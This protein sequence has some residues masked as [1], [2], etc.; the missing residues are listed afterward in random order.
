MGLYADPSVY[1]ILSTPGT[2]G[3]VDDFE[4]VAAALGVRGTRWYEPACGTGRYLRVLRGRGYRAGGYDRD[5]GMVAYAAR[6]LGRSVRAG[7]MTDAAAPGVR[8]GSVDVAFNP[9][10]TIRHL[11]S[12]ADMRAHFAQVARLL[13]PGGIYIVGI[14]LDDPDAR[15]DEDLWQA[16]RGRCR[17]SQLV[18]YLPPEPG[19]RREAVISHL[20][21][22]RPRGV[23][24]FDDRYDLR[25]YTGAQWRRLVAG[26]A[27][28]SVGSFDPFG[29]PLEGRI[30]PYQLEVLY[31]RK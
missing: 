18:N 24:H 19:T 15:P 22:T 17:V 31:L 23:E 27:L 4:R 11:T 10:N 26:S 14:S 28:R 5:P 9:V 21:V 30:L 6:R 7:S 2:A 12:D 25:S 3:E 8:A 20:V 29:K 16:R 13:A 1:D